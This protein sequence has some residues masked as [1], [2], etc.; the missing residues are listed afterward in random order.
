MSEFLDLVHAWA[1]LASRA[2]TESPLGAALLTL[3][4]MLGFLILERRSGSTRWTDR[5]LRFSIALVA[6]AIVIPVLGLFSDADDAI[7]RAAEGTLSGLI[8][9]GQLISEA[10]ER[11][12]LVVL[13]LFVASC[14]TFIVWHLL[15]PRQPPGLLK[16]FLCVAL[17][18]VGVSISYPI[19]SALRGHTPASAWASLFR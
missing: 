15:R 9:S 17:F 13:A 1:R 2:Y 7:W 4:A 14:V 3:A 19:A 8:R 11:Y 16:A 5:T 12:P 6:W 18:A 10:Y